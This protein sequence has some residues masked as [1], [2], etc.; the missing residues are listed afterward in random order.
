MRIRPW[1]Q[2]QLNQPVWCP[3]VEGQHK[4]SDPG[5]W[6]PVDLGSRLKHKWQESFG[7]GWFLI[8]NK[9]P[10][11][12]TSSAATLTPGPEIETLGHI[13]EIPPIKCKT[14]MVWN[15]W[16]TFEKMTED[17][18]YDFIW[19]LRLI[20]N[21]PLKVAQ[22]DMHTKTDGKQVEN[23]WENDQRPECFTYLGVRSG[24]NIRPL[25]HILSTHLK[26]L[27]MS[28]WTDVKPMK[29]FLRKWP[30]TSIFTLLL[31]PKR[32]RNWAFEAHIVHIS[33]SSSNEN[34]K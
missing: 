3:T 5:W 16:K 31:G 30:K 4:G 20:F 27:A 32:P 1:L 22:I 17:L 18:N 25:R 13:I 7:V 15:Q 26:V 14:R 19:P 8:H 9:R 24:P 11:G 29:T 23:F 33:E 6:T 12:L 2:Q 28:M 21:T 34:I 10:D